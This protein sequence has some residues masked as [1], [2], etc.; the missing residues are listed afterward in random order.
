MPKILLVEDNADNIDIVVRRLKKRGYEMLVAEDGIEAC[1][2]A[3]SESPDL[4]LMD[5]NLPLMDGWEAT[6]RI[7]ADKQTSKIPVIALTALAMDGDREKTREAGCDD[8]VTKPIDL[9]QLLAKM[10][11]LLAGESTP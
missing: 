6:R 5:I 10:K 4:I 7:K 9:K 8:Y 11:T 3:Q 1:E 2:K